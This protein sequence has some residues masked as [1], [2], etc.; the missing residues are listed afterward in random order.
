MTLADV[1][2]RCVPPT[3]AQTIGRLETGTRTVSVGWLN[4][5]AGALGVTAAELVT[6]P[7]RADLPIIALLGR[8]GVNAPAKPML[9]ATPQAEAGIMV[10]RVEEGIG[11]YRAGDVIWCERIEPDQMGRALNR[12]VIVPRPAGRFAFGRMIGRED[13][14]LLLLPLMSGARQTVI[15]D[16]P[17]IGVARRMVREL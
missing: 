7:E 10:I 5:I 9:L 11:D 1:A 12:D 16:P 8:D 2:E 15:N 13:M 6:L 4:R 14:R 3:T 17:W